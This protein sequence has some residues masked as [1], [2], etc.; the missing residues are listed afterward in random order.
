MATPA[1]CRLWGPV[2]LGLFGPLVGSGSAAEPVRHAADPESAAGVVSRDGPSAKELVRAALSAEAAG[3]AAEREKLLRRALEKDPDCAPAH[4]HSGHVREGK[5][6]IAWEEAQRRAAGDPRIAEYRRRFG[7]QAGTPAGEL[8]LAR[9]CRDQGL[10]EHARSHWLWLLAIEPQ[11]E[12][13]LKALGVRWYQGQ[14]LTHEQIVARRRGQASQAK[15][16]AEPR[17]PRKDWGRHWAPRVTRWQRMV[18][19]K[20]PSVDSSL[21]EE[22]DSIEKS[23]GPDFWPAMQALGATLMTRSQSKKDQATCL[24]LSLKWIQVLDGR[25]KHPATLL[26]AWL[27]V[28]HPT[29]E[30]REAAAGAL[31]KRPLETFVPILLARM[32]SPVEASFA[33]R[34]TFGSVSWECTFYREGP[35]ADVRVT[36]LWSGGFAYAGPSPEESTYRWGQD[37]ARDQRFRNQRA[38]DAAQVNRA[39]A[40]ATARAAAQATIAAR[41]VQQALVASNAAIETLNGRIREALSRATGTDRGESASAWWKWWEDWCYDHYELEKPDPYVKKKV[42]CEF[43]SAKAAYRQVASPGPNRAANSGHSCFARGTIVWTLTGPAAIDTLRAGDRVL[44]QHPVTGELAFRPVIET[45]TRRLGALTKIH[46]GTETL[47]ATRGH[48]FLVAGEGWTLAK[49]LKTGMRLHSPSGAVPV[50]G[51][52][53]VTDRK[54]FYERLTEEPQADVGDDLAYNLVVDESHT[55][56]VGSR[57]VLV[58]DDRF[59]TLANASPNLAVSAK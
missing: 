2:V 4:W 13:A 40:A 41:Q 7:E 38:A 31:K 19:D 24:A 43:T 52:E 5:Q 44:S 49:D 17:A 28:D 47:T 48:P 10:D 42:V 20:D 25:D 21:R 9:W 6:W 1:A 54:P 34:P 55:Y 30:V 23:F 53:N 39:A 37:S 45:T 50:D 8:A 51:L 12:E 22:L 56:F 58:F 29:P 36:R 27:A 11:N 32:Q 57:R 15:D 3:N 14:L 26:L 59:A 18:Q 35:A 16:Q 46:L 33:I